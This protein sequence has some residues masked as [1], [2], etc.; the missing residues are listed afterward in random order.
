M[1]SSPWDAYSQHTGLPSSLEPYGH[2]FSADMRS[3]AGG[4]AASGM[5]GL[6]GE[7]VLGYPKSSDLSANLNLASQYAAYGQS[8]G[9]PDLG[10]PGSS[11]RPSSTA[12]SPGAAAENIP[13]SSPH[14]QYSGTPT[15]EQSSSPTFPNSSTSLYTPSTITSSISSS[16]YAQAFGS[17]SSSTEARGP[18][19]SPFAQSYG[20]PMYG[21]NQ[22]GGFPTSNS[23]DGVNRYMGGI[24]SSQLM[25]SSAMGLYSNSQASQMPFPY[26]PSMGWGPTIP[27]FPLKE[28]TD[29]MSQEEL[30][31]YRY[32]QLS[33][34]Y[35]PGLPPGGP[36]GR[37]FPSHPLQSGM[38][39]TPPFLDDRV[40][41]PAPKK[42]K[43]S[44]EEAERPPTPAPRDPASFHSNRG[45]YLFTSNPEPGSPNY[46]SD[47]YMMFEKELCEKLSRVSLPGKIQYVY[48]PLE[49]AF[50]SHL[51][52]VRRF[53]TGEKY[54]LFVGMNPGPFG[55]SQNGVPFGECAIVKEWLQ[56]E[57]EVLKPV[58][59]HP[60]RR[61]VGLECSRS[62][63]TGGRF[64]QLF[65]TLCHTPEHF[66]RTSYVHNLCPFAFLTDSGK[67]VTPPQLTSSVLDQI[68]A[69]CNATLVDVVRLL[70]CKYVVCIG[71]YA[72]AQAQKALSA[73]EFNGITLECLM[74][75]SPINPAANKGWADIAI[76]Q[77]TEIGIIDIIR[78]GRIPYQAPSQ[79]QSLPHSSSSSSAGH[80]SHHHHSY[81]NKQSPGHYGF[82]SPPMQSYHQSPAQG[83]N[84][85][86]SPA[87]AASHQSP[88]QA[89]SRSS[90]AHASQSRNQASPA[91]SS[92]SQS[93]AQQQS[94]GPP[95]QSPEHVLGSSAQSLV[96][97][98]KESKHP[99][100]DKKSDKNSSKDS[101]LDAS[102]NSDKSQDSQGLPQLNNNGIPNYSSDSGG[103]GHE[104][105][106]PNSQ[107][108]SGSQGSE[109]S[110]GSSPN[111]QYTSGNPGNSSEPQ[112]MGHNSQLSSSGLMSSANP[113]MHISMGSG[114][115]HMGMGLS[116]T[117][118]PGLHG[119]SS[120]QHSS[121]SG[122]QIGS[123]QMSTS[124]SHMGSQNSHM[125]SI[126]SHMG[127]SMAHMMGA[128]SSHQMTMGVQSM[129]SHGQMSSMNPYAP[130]HM[131]MPQMSG[132]G[133]GLG[134]YPGNPGMRSSS[135]LSGYPPHM[136]MNSGMGMS[137][138]V[139][140]HGGPMASQMGMFNPHMSRMMAG[141]E[142]MSM[143]AGMNSMYDSSLMGKDIGYSSHYSDKPPECS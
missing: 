3:L 68:N 77:L 36:P 80:H 2:P 30:D 107:S 69:L 20:Y 88:A 18:P 139:G 40:H 98:N 31:R 70:K 74:H 66:F 89:S 43:K 58:L 46:F 142:H 8:Y 51:N 99:S 64:W 106:L 114:H 105:G 81:H 78:Y 29:L 37:N 121:L 124:N 92:C 49:Y 14:G 35:F 24:S 120:E 73:D 10:F 136:G 113:Q 140:M 115:P 79:Q 32:R 13:A 16:P 19:F 117:S 90:P 44:T 53:C 9:M 104:N 54:I 93:P 126:N 101:L 55:M 133:M 71:K 76:K 75:P 5:S 94:Q 127:S 131:D 110:K 4:S 15:S 83:S 56:I 48:N 135:D 138:M 103:Q 7:G 100:K 123:P 122:Q 33:N 87:H 125:G 116:M 11:L 59:E 50:D 41:S 34:P 132:Y 26:H 85:H 52:F 60:K 28:S 134:G 82:Q 1:S 47:R 129:G 62:E 128:Q 86:Q 61:V 97:Q 130:Q 6:G 112:L 23:L 141:P 22:V 27:G 102:S 137:G 67:N 72:L 45:I 108:E 39:R 42:P 57:G 25:Q 95:N 119:S 63:V 143:H 111:S 17:T 38:M 96:D 12:H 65:R 21:Y 118:S 91:H 84:N 109:V